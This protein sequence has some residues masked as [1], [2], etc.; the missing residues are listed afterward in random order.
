MRHRRRLLMGTCSMAVLTM[1][2]CVIDYVMPSASLAELAASSHMMVQ[3]CW[4]P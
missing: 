3:W 1:V 2:A 4:E